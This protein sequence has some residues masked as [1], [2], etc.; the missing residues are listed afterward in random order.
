MKKFFSLMALVLA[1]V[2][3]NVA[4]NSCSDDDDA[5]ATPAAAE[6]AGTYSGNGT[7]TVM[8]QS[9]DYPN[10]SYTLTA[11][12]ESTVT[13]TIPATGEGSM[14]FPDLKVENISVTKASDGTY[15]LGETEYKGTVTV[16][17]ATKNYTVMV[18]SSSVNGS[19]LKLNYSLQYGAMPM[20]M[21]TTFEG[22]KTK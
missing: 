10:V 13:L 20:A 7:M 1:I 3:T 8:G 18:A 12:D 9:F 14:K 17:G 4:F 11:K 19:T 5:A 21:V 6:V 22:T 15:T 16:D 2:C